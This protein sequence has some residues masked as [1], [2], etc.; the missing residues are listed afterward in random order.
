MKKNSAKFF[1]NL[2]LDWRSVSFKMTSFEGYFYFYIIS[3]F[4]IFWKTLL[5]RNKGE[6]E[7]KVNK[8]NYNFCDIKRLCIWIKI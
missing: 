3:A 1:Q 4:N 5:A 7:N 8:N 2:I 6:N